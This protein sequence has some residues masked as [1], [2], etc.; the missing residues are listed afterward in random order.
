MAITR[1]NLIVNSIIGEGT[2][3]RGDFELNGLL[4]I[5]GMFTGSIESE[6]KVLVGQLGKAAV[7]RIRA[8]IVIIGGEVTGDII[9]TQKVTILSTGIMN[10]NIETPRLIAEEGVS[11]NGSINIVKREADKTEKEMDDDKELEEARRELDI[12]DIQVQG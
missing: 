11:L 2:K 8:A 6:G 5:D 1:E 3:F 4:R 7:G 9:A 12:K 10:G